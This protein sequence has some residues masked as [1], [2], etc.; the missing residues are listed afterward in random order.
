MRAFAPELYRFAYRL[1]GNHQVAE[2]LVQ[3]TF[4]EAWRSLA[5]QREPGK[6][7][8]WMYQILRY[9]YAHYVRDSKTRIRAE[10]LEE[11]ISGKMDPGRPGVD[12]VAERES[13][14]MALSH[15][16]VD[17]RETFLMV[18][19]QGFKCREAAEELK[20]PLGTVLSRL[21]RAREVLRAAVE[22]Q[23]QNRPERKMNLADES[24]V[25]VADVSGEGEA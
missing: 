16:S 7:R 15:L 21:S 9:R 17:V 18:F 5:K 23:G 25:R 22:S 19:M 8:A 10:P 6:E 2:D 14:Q 24:D 3:E 4:V 13:L 11:E 1:A 12:A 20:V